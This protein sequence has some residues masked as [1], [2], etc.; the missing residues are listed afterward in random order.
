VNKVYILQLYSAT[1]SSLLRE[2]AEKLG[3]SL[4]REKHEQYDFM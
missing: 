2:M 4:E 3:V 1:F